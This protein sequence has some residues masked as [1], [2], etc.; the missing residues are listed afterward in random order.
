[1]SDNA[2]KAVKK[3]MMDATNKAAAKIGG[4]LP[5]YVSPSIDKN[6]R[7]FIQ[8]F[9][10]SF[11]ENIEKINNE[12]DPIGLLI[13]AQ[14]GIP[15]PSYMVLSD[16]TLVCNLETL[17]L[18]DRVQIAKFLADKVMPRINIDKPKDLDE[19]GKLIEQTAKKLVESESPTTKPLIDQDQSQ[20]LE[21]IEVQ[22]EV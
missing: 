14:L 19:F 12:A 1:M 18:K 3:A 7:S 8:S 6:R 17:G 15:I 9:K 13:A 10:Q 2:L 5:I 21:I 20:D 22:D 11:E 16:G 4:D